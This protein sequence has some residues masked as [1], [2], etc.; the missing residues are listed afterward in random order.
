MKTILK[1]KITAL[2]VNCREALEQTVRLRN[3]IDD[4][5]TGNYPERERILK[6]GQFL[7]KCTEQLELL[8]S[9]F[10]NIQSELDNNGKNTD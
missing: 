6:I 7:G 5:K 1:L 3:Q 9:L 8:F 2:E 10:E 4:I